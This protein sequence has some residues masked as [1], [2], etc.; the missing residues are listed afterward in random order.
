MREYVSE[1]HLLGAGTEGRIDRMASG[2]VAALTRQRDD[3]ATDGPWWSILTRQY[4]ISSEENRLGECSSTNGTKV[5]IKRACISL[6]CR[7]AALKQNTSLSVLS[8]LDSSNHLLD[9]MKPRTRYELY[10]EVGAVHI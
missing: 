5:Q 4:R 10:R 8:S 3:L 6:C 7:R 1:M 2:I 9:Y